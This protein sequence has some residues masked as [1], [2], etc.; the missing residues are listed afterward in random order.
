MLD[1]GERSPVYNTAITLLHV[2]IPTMSGLAEANIDMHYALYTDE[3]H[4]YPIPFESLISDF[5]SKSSD[6]TGHDTYDIFTTFA[7]WPAS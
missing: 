6:S 1:G 5:A 7:A 2:D 3:G 4:S